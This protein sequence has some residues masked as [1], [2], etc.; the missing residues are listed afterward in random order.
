MQFWYFLN[1]IFLF[2]FT[3]RDI[4]ENHRKI[5]TCFCIGLEELVIPLFLSKS[6]M[7]LFF[8][9]AGTLSL[10]FRG[11]GS[12]ETSSRDFDKVEN[13]GDHVAFGGNVSM[14]KMYFD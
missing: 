1:V 11:S 4:S 13:Q 9:R 8:M 12:S 6:F 5:V 2:F 7:N 10:V 14:E 3:F